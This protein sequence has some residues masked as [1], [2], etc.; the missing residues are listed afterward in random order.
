VTIATVE[1]SRVELPKLNPPNNTQEGTSMV[2]KISKKN[3]ALREKLWPD[4][5][6]EEIW[7]HKDYDG[8]LSVPR[9]MPIILG[10]IND[11]TKGKPAGSTYFSLWCMTYPAEMYVSLSNAEELAFQSGFKGQRAVR[12]WQDRMKSLAEFG[13]VK[14]AEGARGKLSHAAIPNPHFVIRRLHNEK[15]AGLTEAAFNTL[16]ERANEIGA[17]DI[18]I[19]MPEEKAAREAAEAAAAAKSNLDDEIPF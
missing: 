6:H 13:F 16:W 4:L 9:T 12:Q 10:I 7:H 5:V 8:F 14:V 11:L 19:E 15:T 18:E 17:K 2:K 1:S 3:I